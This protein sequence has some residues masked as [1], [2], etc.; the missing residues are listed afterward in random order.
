MGLGKGDAQG[1]IGGV[2]H[3]AVGGSKIQVV[4]RDSTPWPSDPHAGYDHF[5][6]SESRQG[7]EKLVL[8]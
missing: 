2:P 6:F 7:T 8:G 4:V 5:V 3:G 1:Q